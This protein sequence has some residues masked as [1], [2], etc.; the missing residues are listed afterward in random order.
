M[1]YPHGYAGPPG[2]GPGYSD[3]PAVQAGVSM[4][5]GSMQYPAPSDFQGSAQRGQAPPS[6][7]TSTPQGQQP[8][9]ANPQQQAAQGGTPYHQHMYGFQQT[10][11]QPTPPSPYDNVQQYGA[12]PRQSAAA[13]DV[14]TNQFG[15]PQGYYV[16]NPDAPGGAGAGGPTSAPNTGMAA[17]PQTGVPQGYNHPSMSYTTQ[18]P[19]VRDSMAYATG[20]AA[21]TASAAT[22]GPQAYTATYAEQQTSG[23]DMDQAYNQYQNELRRTFEHVR[24]GRLQ[25]AGTLLMRISEW[26]LGNADNLGMQ[27]V[28][29]CV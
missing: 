15:V 13:I 18:S 7:Q 19:V 16:P 10:A 6:Q 21:D 9:A 11:Q 4:P 25:E 22:A 14:L 17:A 29:R 20:M 26:L 5:A 8:G 12:P 3:I 2:A 27:F 23:T 24:D 28:F 1:S